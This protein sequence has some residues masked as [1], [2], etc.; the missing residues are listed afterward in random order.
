MPEV[1]LN[2]TDAAELTEMLQFL[3]G[4]LTRDPARLAASLKS[5][6]ATPPTVWANC[7]PTWN[8]SPSCSAA[9]NNSSAHDRG[10][11]G[12]AGTPAERPSCRR[13]WHVLT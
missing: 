2:A 10:F 3:T 5:S 11:P 6:P 7:A 1:R 4:W 8:G 9:A 12:P 13:C